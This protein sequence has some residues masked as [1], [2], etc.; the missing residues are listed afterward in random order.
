MGQNKTALRFFLRVLSVTCLSFFIARAASAAR[1]LDLSLFAL[2]APVR[3]RSVQ[4]LPDDTVTIEIP[5]L[6]NLADT[7]ARLSNLALDPGLEAVD[8]PELETTP[9]LNWE[10]LSAVNETVS[11]TIPGNIFPA[12]LALEGD[13]AY[14]AVAVN[15]PAAE[16]SG[17]PW[18]MATGIGFALA[19]VV[20]RRFT[21]GSRRRSG[22]RASPDW[23]RAVSRGATK[24]DAAKGDAAKTLLSLEELERLPDTETGETLELLDGEWIQLPPLEKPHMLR[25]EELFKKLDRALELARQR[26]P[27]IVAG[28]VHIEMGYLLAGRPSSCFVPDVSVTWP[29]QPGHRYYER[30]PM[31]AVELVSDHDL[32][33]DIERKV[34]QYLEHGAAEVWIV[35]PESRH[36]VVYSR[37]HSIER[38]D[39]AFTTA[40]LPGIEIPFHEFL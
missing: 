36:S 37:A 27:H 12:H 35:Y 13:P 7:L 1:L 21:R 20:G 24:G 28:R 2:D 33:K 40:L 32:A 3:A 11:D 16:A 39:R 31:I 15:R 34:V 29:D 9:P 8:G 22:S 14:F 4:V 38:N 18:L 30:S 17:P 26:N 5:L 23:G 25:A 19:G 10:I 6:T